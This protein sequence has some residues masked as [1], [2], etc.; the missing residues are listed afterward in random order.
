MRKHTHPKSMVMETH[1]WELLEESC[2][3][4]LYLPPEQRQ[5]L[6]LRWAEEEEGQPEAKPVQGALSNQM[7]YTYMFRSMRRG[8]PS[9]EIMGLFINSV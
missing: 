4:C 8:I 9:V 7:V 3:L 6:Q 5:N 1:E 2:A